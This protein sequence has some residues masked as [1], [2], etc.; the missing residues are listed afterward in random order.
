M[1]AYLFAF[2]Y[3]ITTMPS[4]EDANMDGFLTREQAAKIMS[5]Y[6]INVL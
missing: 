2:K 5:N 4:C 3:H 6:A 1:L